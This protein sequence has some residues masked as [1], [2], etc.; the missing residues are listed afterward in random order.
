MPFVLEQ[1]VFGISHFSAHLDN[2]MHDFQELPQNYV[3]DANEIHPD[4]YVIHNDGNV[5]NDNCYVVLSLSNSQ[6]D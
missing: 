5:S 4:A 1:I 2:S 6:I 3:D